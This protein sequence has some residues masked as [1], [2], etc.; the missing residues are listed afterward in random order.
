MKEKQAILSDEELMRLYNQGDEHSFGELYKRYEGKAY[1]YLRKRLQN[2]QAA[3]DV[4]QTAFLKLH[5]SK[6]QFNSS[7]MFA[8]WFFTIIKTS[9]LDW[10]KNQQNKTIHIELKDDFRSSP[11]F[12]TEIPSIDRGEIA[13]LP[14]DQ[15]SAVEMRYVE[16]LSF[17][18]IAARL[19]TS[20]TNVR[21]LVSRGI[22]SLRAIF[23]KGGRTK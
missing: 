11:A 7:F 4:F 12:I 20:P 14:K 5:R 10:Q 8:P 18:E 6:D 23:L 22:N 16:D 1:G 13:R 21:K 15:R 2:P 17:E 3:N 19:N 9:L